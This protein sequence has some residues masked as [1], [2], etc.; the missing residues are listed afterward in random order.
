M[1]A[2]R[3][4][5]EHFRDEAMYQELYNSPLFPLVRELQFKFGLKVI[6]NVA[7]AWLLGHSNGIAVGKVFLKTIDDKP[8]YC[9]RSPF[10]SKERGNSRED[11]ETIRS[12]KISSLVAT[13]SR[14]KIIPAATDM[15]TRK[16]KQVGTAQEILK[17]SLGESR[18][19]GELT[20]D[21]IHALLLMALGRNPNSEWVKVDQNK[22][23]SVLDKYEEADRVRKTKVEEADRMFFNPYWMIG[24][25]EFGDYLIGKYKLTKSVDGVVGCHAM[26]S[27]SRYRSYEQVPELIPLMTMVKVAY[28]NHGRNCGVLPT[29]DAYDASLDS[30]FFYNTSPTHYDHVWMVTPCST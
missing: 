22:C 6:R 12:G 27:F 9:F 5:I 29:T 8:T 10:Y 14:C 20:T 17:K 4:F 2:E 1:T 11:K 16:A 21:E 7:G 19:T 13:L 28:E 24:V 3:F 23:Q 25:D 30:V 18:K 15:E 26:Q